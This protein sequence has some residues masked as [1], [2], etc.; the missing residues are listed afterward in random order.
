MVITYGVKLVV[1][2]CTKCVHVQ[3]HTATVIN[4]HLPQMSQLLQKL[5]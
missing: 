1:G 5:M 3:S 2:A 4:V